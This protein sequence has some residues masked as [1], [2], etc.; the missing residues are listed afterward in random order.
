MSD[1]SFYVLDALQLAVEVSSVT[2]LLF[3]DG[4]FVMSSN[5]QKFTER[6]RERETDGD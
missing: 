2:G 1:A 6:Q 3:V 5:V 4:I